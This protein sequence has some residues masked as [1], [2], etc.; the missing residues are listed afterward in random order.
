MLVQCTLCKKRITLYLHLMKEIPHNRFFSMVFEPICVLV[1]FCQM[2]F[3]DLRDPYFVLELSF[4]K[5][6]SQLAFKALS[7]TSKYV[8]RPLGRI[9]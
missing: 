8:E 5:R 2:K 4:L 7:K 3:F 6:V 9:Q 1:I